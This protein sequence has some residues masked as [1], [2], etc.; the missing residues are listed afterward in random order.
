MRR[1]LPL[2]LLFSVALLISLGCRPPKEPEDGNLSLT[3]P[4]SVEPP[5]NAPDRVSK[6]TVDGKDFSQ[7]R[8]TQRM[9]KVTAADDKDE[10]KVVYTFW[11]NTYTE[12][13]RTKVVKLEKGKK[14]EASLMNADDATP[15]LIKPIYVP[16]SKE[17]T[18]QMCKM[19]KIGPDDVVYDIGCGDGII[20]ITAVQ[21]FGAKKG[22]GIDIREDLIKD[23]LTN[24]KKAGVADKVEFRVADALKV[25]DFSEASV[26]LL[27]LGDKLNNAL[28]PDLKA[29]LKPGSRIVSHRFKMGD[30]WPPDASEPIA[31]DKTSNEAGFDLHFWKIKADPNKVNPGP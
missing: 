2:T 17:V 11:Y 24:A 23:C 8:A 5:V 10:V 18:E 29:S 31:V 9:L 16:T 14:V 19:A 15:D 3:L 20:V 27:Y 21:K 25:K 4:E 26:V 6:L 30:D 7:P 1:F 22:V 13:I 28:K 12:I